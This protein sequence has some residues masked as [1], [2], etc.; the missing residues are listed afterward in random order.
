MLHFSER[1]MAH[2]QLCSEQGFL[3][4]EFLK[5]KMKLDQA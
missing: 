3:P 2:S 5:V 4:V 1:W